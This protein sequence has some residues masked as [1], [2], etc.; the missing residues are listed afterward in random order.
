MNRFLLQ[1]KKVLK[2]GVAIPVFTLMV[3]SATFAQV[4]I[5]NIT[6]GDFINGT[7]SATAT[8]VLNGAAGTGPAY[9]KPSGNLQGLTSDGADNIAFIEASPARIMRIDGTHV[10]TYPA[11]TNMDALAV[12]HDNEFIY[13]ASHGTPNTINRYVWK[14]AGTTSMGYYVGSPLGTVTTAVKSIPFITSGDLVFMNG[15]ATST[16]L[17]LGKITLSMAFDASG[18]MYYGDNTNNVV[19]KISIEKATPTAAVSGATTITLSA[20]PSAAVKVGDEVSGLYI[21]ATTYI[22]AISG[23]AITLSKAT[24]GVID[25]SSTLA[26]ITGVSDIAG[27]FG[28]AGTTLG[29]T[30]ATTVLQ[31]IFGLTIDPSG[32]LFV[33]DQNNI[34]PRILKISAPVSSASAI[35][36][37]GSGYSNRIQG[38]AT[39]VNGNLYLAD[40]SFQ[41]VLKVSANGGG[42]INIV[43]SGNNVILSNYSVTAGSPVVTTTDLTDLL[44]MDVGMTIRGTGIPAGTTVT[45]INTQTSP[46]SLTLSNPGGTTVGT[47]DG[48]ATLGSTTLTVTSASGIAAGNYVVGAGIPA[49]T[50]VASIT[51]TTVTLSAATTAALAVTQL[52]FF[53]P[54]VYNTVSPYTSSNSSSENNFTTAN[55]SYGYVENIWGLAVSHDAN[56]PYIVYDENFENY[57]RKISGSTITTATNIPTITSFTPTTTSAGATVTITGT[58]FTGATN[59]NFGGV[60]ATSFTVVSP[61][62]ITA[63]VGTGTN[64]VVFITTPS[65]T[66]FS[67]S[68]IKIT[69]TITSFTPTSGVAGTTVTITGT[70]FLTGTPTVTFGGTAVAAASVT[71]NNNTTIT[72]VTGTGSGGKIVVTTASGTA[73]STG[74]FT[75][76]SAPTSLSYATAAPA[77]YGTAGTSGA[78]ILATPNVLTYTI[79]PA[80]P[81]GITIDANTGIISYDNTIVPGSYPFTVTATNN[82]GSIS[83]AYTLTVNAT[84]PAALVY[85]TNS[86]TAIRGTAGISVAPTV[87]NGGAT[88]TYSLTGTVPGNIT[89]N[90]T[91][92]VISYDN[93]LTV[94]NY[95]LTVTATNV[96][97]STTVTY[98]INI[99]P[100]PNNN[101]SNLSINTGTLTPAFNSA[102]I[103]YVVGVPI[104]TTS[105]IFTPTVSD[106]FALV[107]V[108]GINVASGSPSS[109]VSLSSG[110][111][112]I[113]IVVTA[114]DG[115][116]KTYTVNVIQSSLSNNAQLSAMVLSSGTLSP[117]FASAITNY[118]ASV[119]NTT[120]SITVTPTLANASATQ[121]VNGN[122]VSSGVAS[123][124]IALNVGSNIINTVVSAQ[125][126]VTAIT[127]TVDVN[128]AASANNN[129][130]ALTIS[131]GSLS[132]VFSSGTLNYAATVANTVTTISFTPVVAD[133]TA[134]VTI[135]GAA[136]TSGSVSTGILLNV[137]ANT[138]TISVTAQNGSVNNYTVIVTKLG[139]PETITFSALN[140][141]N[142][143]SA[144]FAAGA[145]STNSTV[146]VTYSSSNTGVATVAADGTIHILSAGSTV[147]TVSQASNTVYEAATPATRTL[148][149][150]PAALTVTANNQSRA[151]GTANPALTVTYTG[152][153]NGDNATKLTNQPLVTTTATTTSG[154]G[155]YPITVSVASSPNYTISYVPGVLTITGGA[156]TI[157]FAALA[158]KTYG[159]ADFPLTATISSGETATYVSSDPTIATVVNGTVHIVTAGSVTITAS[160][161]A[162]GNY[163]TTAT[164]PQILVINK[165][166]Q[167]I[168]F[169]A[170]PTQKQGGSL[171]LNATAS[172]GLPVTFTSSDPKVATINGQSADLLAQGL[173][174]ITAIQAGDINYLP[175]TASQFLKIQ[176]DLVTVH[177]GLSPNGDGINDYLL[178]DGISAYPDNKLTIIDRNG[179]KVFQ[180]SN[181]D[182][183]SNNFTG[184]SNS[185]GTLQP[186]T[187]FYELVLNVNGESKRQ[188][189]YIVLKYN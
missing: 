184:H 75:F 89:I 69:P 171:Q 3:S 102:T 24:T 168:N 120:T 47:P 157:T 187:Y 124:P 43:G 33:N 79:S 140:P 96:T 42:A 72:V 32:N 148:T 93:A 30:G 28:T 23:N 78:P 143:G 10:I 130:S 163:T 36:V 87:N 14:N 71:I 182:N 164:V 156:R 91:T 73:T 59:V 12:D 35:A 160:A 94:G 131:S 178:I 179:A 100:S 126:G 13:A 20:A 92:G 34:N 99:N 189:G 26:I 64:G 53:A 77:N 104:S 114:Q 1:L 117:S 56:N 80:P 141:V 17:N 90:A 67:S 101:L 135:N 95:S 172:T 55:G 161:P 68:S 145:S 151:Y 150:N 62:S 41:R 6:S 65:G 85:S 186:G 9:Y 27:T 4:S 152:F 159:D 74:S 76:I 138:I 45:A 147:I 129:L 58:N 103:S 8:S 11:I 57:V 167:T 2:S 185:G 139:L 52:F 37:F 173:T 149:V 113:N 22:T 83:T 181:Y 110:T 81:A 16:A 38:M 15:A 49:N 60:D 133:P 169:A 115:T 116:T 18:N 176:D 70:N 146:P 54:T 106:A 61:T 137:G 153:V 132:P 158:A 134:T 180:T 29:T 39:D 40:K 121:T 7:A 142:Y 170:I 165:A 44:K 162:N 109:A 105:V 144:D 31:A 118:T 25:N 21:P 50:T 112:N 46:Y 125:D 174:A 97:G 122:G 123:S 107:Q 48:T 155:T 119:S 111:N 98:T 51:G 128:R 188:A 63:V 154:V 127:Y 5:T 177:P 175:A 82:L 84:A 183:A 166:S 66:A 88:V 86:S 108:N 136:A 19:R